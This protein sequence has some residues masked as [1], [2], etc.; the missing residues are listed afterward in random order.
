MARVDRQHFHYPSLYEEREA[1]G[2][3]ALP[4]TPEY[5]SLAREVRQIV[6]VC[7]LSFEIMTQQHST[8]CPS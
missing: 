3:A 8:M 1:G 5:F 2:G 6:L 4:S 7:S